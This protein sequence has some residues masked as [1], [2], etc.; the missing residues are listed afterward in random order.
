MT[1]LGSIEYAIEH[2]KCKLI[3]VCGHGKCGAV[4][5]AC[6]TEEFPPNIKHILE[7]IKPAVKKG[8]DIDK[9]I[10]INVEEMGNK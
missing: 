10:H 8:G 3:V 7:Y 2:L 6:S 4:T 9:V 1:A 5:A